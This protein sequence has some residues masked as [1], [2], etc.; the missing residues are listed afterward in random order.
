MAHL[1]HFAYRREVVA[2][3]FQPYES[4]GLQYPLDGGDWWLGIE[5]LDLV[6]G[7]WEPSPEHPN[8][9]KP[10]IEGKLT[11]HF[12]GT[13]FNLGDGRSGDRAKAAGRGNG[14][15]EH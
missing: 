2:I 8:K 4:P 1:S 10:P 7:K 3:C 12:L 13:G 9:S 14:A 11:S 6:E 5:L 15:G